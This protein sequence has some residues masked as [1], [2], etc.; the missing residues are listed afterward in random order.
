MSYPCSIRAALRLCL[1]SLPGLV[2]F[3]ALAEPS[4]DHSTAASI[5]LPQWES[6]FSTYQPF[7]DQP[8]L[9]WQRLNDRVKEIG[10]WRTYAMEPYEDESS[11]AEQAPARSTAPDH[12][13]HTGAH[14]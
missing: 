14:Q 8:I 6:V 10:G 11:E 7:T 2:A 1:G 3:G 5:Q 13:S 4:A 9:S 12:T